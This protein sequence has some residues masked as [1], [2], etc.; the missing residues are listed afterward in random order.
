MRKGKGLACIIAIVCMII[1]GCLAGAGFAMG[2]RFHDG[3]GIHL[4]DF[5]WNTHDVTRS[6]NMK[7]IISEESFQQIYIDLHVGDIEV[8]R[9]ST[10]QVLVK[11]IPDEN[12]DFS[13]KDG[14]LRLTTHDFNVS[15]LSF[16]SLEYEVILIVPE[17]ASLERIELFSNMG[18][19]DVEDVQWSYLM[20]E[21]QMGDVDISHTIVDGDVEI[22]QKMGDVKFEGEISGMA[23][24]HNAMGDIKMNLAYLEAYDLKTS[25]GSIKVNDQSESHGIGG[26]IKSGN[27]NTKNILIAKN[28]MGDIKLEFKK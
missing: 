20:I 2:G 6:T 10:Y 27:Q 18:D 17:D 7:K 16:G 25:M 9:G 15:N 1:G 21:Q 8:R 12:Y 26:H 19:V 3:F 5:G 4:N 23:N 13:I 24:V 28:A 22:E 14:K 11:N